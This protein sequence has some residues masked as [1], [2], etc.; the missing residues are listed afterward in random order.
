MQK[1]LT[2]YL[3]INTDSH[4]ALTLQKHR[5]LIENRSSKI[6]KSLWSETLITVHLHSSLPLGLIDAEHASSLL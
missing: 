4:E 3:S 1:R 6:L 5:W 2:F